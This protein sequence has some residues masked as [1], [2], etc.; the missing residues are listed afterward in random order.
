MTTSSTSQ[1]NPGSTTQVSQTLTGLTPGSSYVILVRAYTNNSDGTKTY[2]DYAS[3]PYTDSGVSAS[4]LNALTVNNGTDI[5]LNGGAIYAQNTTNPFKP[6]V[7]VFD[8]VNGTTTGTGVILNNTG[9][10]AFK[11]GTREFYIDARTGNAYFSG[12]V[13]ATII[14]STGYSSGDVTDGSAY[15]SGG[16][17]INLNNGSLTSKNFRIDTSGNAYFKGDVASATV[18][19]TTLS[20]TLSTLNSSISSAFAAAYAAQTSA[21]GKNKIWYGSG[22][23]STSGY[24]PDGASYTI[25]NA[26]GTTASSSTFP[27]SFPVSG[28]NNTV[29][30]GTAGDTWFVYNTS[31]VVIAQYTCLGGTSWKQTSIDGLTIANIDAGAITG[32][33]ISAGIL[34]QG[35][36]IQTGSTGNYVKISAS[37]SDRITFNNA[38][39]NTPGLIQST[40]NSNTNIGTLYISSGYQST[41]DGTGASISLNS[42][43][44]TGLNYIFL[45]NAVFTGSYIQQQNYAQEAGTYTGSTYAPNLTTGLG[46]QADATVRNIVQSTSAPSTAANAA[47]SFVDGDIWIVHS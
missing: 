6:N 2:S 35:P 5:L 41:V 21:N 31:Y 26:S 13:Q 33:T 25:T 30:S 40:F 20:S 42:S 38:G 46:G 3:I 37:N 44:T 11:A 34:I 18:S 15:S 36:T 7:G 22:V 28:S 8:V 12:T 1:W 27:I 17:A 9:L 23:T 39:L 24:A 16:M 43:Y 29:Q 14:E 47:S 45:N 32:G 4:G 19:G 10:A